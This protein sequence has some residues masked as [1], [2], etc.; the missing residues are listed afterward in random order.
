MR[1]LRAAL[2]RAAERFAAIVAFGDPNEISQEPEEFGGTDDGLETVC[3][4]Y[5]NMQF[6]AER[7]ALEIRAALASCDTHPKDGDVEQAPLVSGAVPSET[8]A[9]A[10][11]SSQSED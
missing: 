9:D 11:S 5:E 10:P 6:I 7:G 1:D 3:M 2:E 4:A 8:S